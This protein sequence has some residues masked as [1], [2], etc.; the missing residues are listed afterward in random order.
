MSLYRPGP[1]GATILAVLAEAGDGGLTINAL[2]EALGRPPEQRT[3]VDQAIRAL[4]R[5][6]CVRVLTR[7]R[8]AGPPASVWGITTTGRKAH[9]W[10]QGTATP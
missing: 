3:A 8:G 7:I 9:E 5:N 2:T 6:G 4:D 10:S 1:V